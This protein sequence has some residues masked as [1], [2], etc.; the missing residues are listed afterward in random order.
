MSSAL[1]KAGRNKLKFTDTEPKP[2]DIIRVA[3]RFYYH[4]GLYVSDD[5]VIQFGL[6]DNTGT[7]PKDICVREG[8]YRD[9]CNGSFAETAKLS[10]AEKHKR[11]SVAKTIEYAKSRLGM[12]GY[13]ILHNNCEH[14]VTDCVFGTP[15]SELV[16]QA[17]NEIK[18]KM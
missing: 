1:L 3:A 12:T 5:C 6:A 17:R 4:Y 16:T 9:F 18:G 15:T 14:F 11:R 10:L 2:G 13:D 7:D 8:T